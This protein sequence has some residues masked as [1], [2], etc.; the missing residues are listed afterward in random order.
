[1]IGSDVWLAD[2][3]TILGGV[4]IGNG[5]CVGAGSIVTKSI[6]P[7]RI[8]AG[9]PC[10][11]LALRFPEEIVA[12]LQDVEWWNWPEERIRRNRSFFL[13]DLSKSSVD[14]IVETIVD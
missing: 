6:P 4:T 3:V 7:Y 11:I 2:N 14:Q 5:A 1:M 13:L 8:A 10:R 12:L 9:S